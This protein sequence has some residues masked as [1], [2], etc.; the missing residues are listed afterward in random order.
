MG[1]KRDGSNFP[2]SSRN[3]TTP[4]G[5]LDTLL[6]IKQLSRRYASEVDQGQARWLVVKKG[7]EMAWPRVH[8][9]LH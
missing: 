3:G 7:Y 1:E 9:V 4:V 8:R 5:G 6:K 2:A